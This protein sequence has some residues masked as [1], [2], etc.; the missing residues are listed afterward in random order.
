MEK[1]VPRSRLTSLNIPAL[2]GVRS[3]AGLSPAA[4][5]VSVLDRWMARKLLDLLNN[6]PLTFVLW[7]GETVSSS[8]IPS[9]VRVHFRDSEVLQKV[10]VNP[11][12]NF[13]DF[14]STGRVEVEGNLVDF[15][16]LAYR[17]AASSPKYLKLKEAQTRLF[18]RPR[19]NK[20]AD[21]RDNIHHH[22]DI[23]NDFYR[24]WLDQRRHA[25]HLRLLSHSRI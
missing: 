15:L 21:S 9:V 8:D 11:A 12:L 3:G 14:Y 7:N 18:N 22:Y 1:D 13:G 17:A 16:V 5:R 25:I 10:L 4:S 2:T 19:P 20:L 6:P 23:G 24:L